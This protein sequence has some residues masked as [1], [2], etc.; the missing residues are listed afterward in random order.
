LLRLILNIPLAVHLLLLALIALLAAPAFAS[1]YLLPDESLILLSGQKV[2][3]GST[4][5]LEAWYNG[6]PVPVWIYAAISRIFGPS[7][8]LALRL[9]AYFLVY[10]ASVLFG[11]MMAEYKALA[12]YPFLPSILMVILCCGPW[13][14][15]ELSSDILLL[16]PAILGFY[17]LISLSEGNG[18]PH[19]LLFLVGILAGLSFL[20][21]YT[22]IFLI[23][24]FLLL[25]LMIFSPQINQLF[26]FGS[27]AVLFL[28][29]VTMGLYLKR[30]LSA[31]ID[32][33]ILSRI[34]LISSLDL[35]HR[36]SEARETL[37]MY[38]FFAGGM[39]LVG[40]ISF[41]RHR[42]R[43]FSYLVVIRKVELAMMVWGGVALLMLI[44]SGWELHLHHFVFFAP[45]LAFYTARFLDSIDP[46]KL[47]VGLLLFVIAGPCVVFF[48]YGAY[49]WEIA[50]PEARLG[51][52]HGLFFGSR[53]DKPGHFSEVEAYFEN[54]R[55][56]SLWLI[57]HQPELY[58]RLKMDCPVK[59]ADFRLS[60]LKISCFHP[61][62]KHTT[63]SKMEADS[64]IYSEFDSHPPDYILDRWGFFDKLETR[65][66]TIFGKYVPA[67]T[68]ENYIIYQR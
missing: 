65:F 68:I 45:P 11:G 60:F 41:G 64:D 61:E 46:V 30:N 36:F 25:Y 16:I 58:H 43:F 32:L 22:A 37:L 42:L 5:Y 44:L 12:R 31:F 10:L 17:L 51:K 23:L 6:A 33:G 26:S 67:D 8:F 48:G 66:P 35:L 55:G 4:L 28:F 9:L 50:G 27:G 14:G 59:Y 13:Y 53:E 63:V 57:A 34:D 2:A 56:K 38:L 19:P 62:D 40:I 15:F 24:G 49:K 29:L 21:A 18:H 52:A 54:K 1:G 7:A 47:R 3:S 39:V 20:T